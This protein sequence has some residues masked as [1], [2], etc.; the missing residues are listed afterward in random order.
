MNHFD[1][2]VA[3]LPGRSYRPLGD[4]TIDDPLADAYDVEHSPPPR[5]QES[6][7]P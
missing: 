3:T 5:M 2:L 7:H 6:E 1:L 4:C